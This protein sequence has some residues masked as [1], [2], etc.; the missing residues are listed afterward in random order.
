MPASSGSSARVHG[1]AGVLAHRATQRGEPRGVVRFRP[2]LVASAWGFVAWLVLLA[3]CGPAVTTLSTPADDIASALAAAPEGPALGLPQEPL[4]PPSVPNDHVLDVLSFNAALLPEPVVSTRQTARARAMAPHVVGYDVLVLQEVFVDAWR[5]GLL[6]A[7]ADAYPYRTEVVGQ[8][9]ARGFWLRQDGG[10]VILSRWPI[11]QQSYVLF[12]GVCSGTD[13][14][15]DKGVA[16][17]A[18]RKGAFTY[19]VFVTHAQSDY[20]WP[21]APRTRAEQF[22]L[23]RAFV[24]DL[25]LPPE[26]PVVLAGDFNVDAWTPE[27][28][29]MLA[30]LNAVWPPVV[31]P[32]RN[33]WDASRNAW[34][35]GGAHWIDY[36]LYG[37]GHEA[38][39]AAW[40]RAVP[41]K[42]GA[43]DLSDHFAVWGRLVMEHGSAA[44]PLPWVPP[45]P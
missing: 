11:V 25:N 13:C 16:Y 41:L 1:H 18:V 7:L 33:T 21:I 20:G 40:N 39:V 43:L 32:L 37:V 26:E 31:G 3:G 15:A 6:E 22:A 12:G 27:R 29:T 45:A 4:D 9:G 28:D 23:M 19:H 35:Y 34:A 2:R 42:D 5:E 24:E 36:V 38:P 44:S 17:A 8:D 14:L 10:I 30:G